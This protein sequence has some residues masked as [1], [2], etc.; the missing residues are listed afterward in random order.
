VLTVPWGGEPKI[1]RFWDARKVAHAGL[2]NPNRGS[3]RELTDELEALLTDAVR[4][5][6]IADV[7]LVVEI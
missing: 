3:D 6:M 2:A 5:R 4:R 7:P 1:E